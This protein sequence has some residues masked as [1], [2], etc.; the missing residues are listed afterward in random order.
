MNLKTSLTALSLVFLTACGGGSSESTPSN[1]KVQTTNTKPSIE[2]ELSITLAAQSSLSHTL[3]LKDPDKDELSVNIKDQPSWLSYELENQSLVFTISPTLF[4]IKLHELEVSVSDGKASS[5]VTLN[6][7]IEY[8][9]VN[10]PGDAITISDQELTGTWTAF[11]QD[12]LIHFADDGKGFAKFGDVNFA[13]SWQNPD[14]IEISTE[15]FECIANCMR[16]QFIPLEVMAKRDNAIRVKRYLNESEFVWLTLNKGEQKTLNHMIYTDQRQ[17]SALRMSSFNQQEDISHYFFTNLSIKVDGYGQIVDFNEKAELKDGIYQFIEPSEER[18]FFGKN[19]EKSFEHIDGTFDRIALIPKLKHAELIA[20]VEDFAVLEFTYHFVPK[21]GGGFNDIDDVSNWPEL[22]KELVDR[23]TYKVFRGAEFI[24]PPEPKAGDVLMGLAPFYNSKLTESSYFKIVN[25]PITMSSATM[26]QYNV[27]SGI[28]G[29]TFSVDVEIV[30]TA[31]GREF[32]VGDKTRSVRYARIYD[33]RVATVTDFFDNN[34]L[35]SYSFATVAEMDTTFEATQDDYM[36][37][38]YVNNISLL[39]LDQHAVMEAREDGTAIVY[40][41]GVF[42]ANGLWRYES[43]NSMSFV[44]NCDLNDT[45]EN[46]IAQNE[47]VEVLNYKLFRK[48]AAGYWFLRTY[49]EKKIY[50][51]GTKGQPIT[52]SMEFLK[53]CDGICIYKSN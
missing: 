52:Q 31:Q 45:V 9:E 13:L 15:E 48:E 23:K 27:Q 17:D 3:T 1:E 11:E 33:N 21:S 44:R 32:T 35:L 2:G 37:T 42:G 25:A 30:D 24:S 34:K 14:D 47:E 53:L 19:Y 38:F 41:G 6:I 36:K 51:D 8:D 22:N 18:S 7:D 29:E 20:S 4:D 26:G 43:D 12:V 16:S 46:C 50:S 40:N 49:S 28:T 10:Y 39:N 5:K